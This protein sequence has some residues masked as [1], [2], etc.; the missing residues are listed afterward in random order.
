MQGELIDWVN[1]HPVDKI[2]RV[3]ALLMVRRKGLLHFSMNVPKFTPLWPYFVYWENKLTKTTTCSLQ[4]ILKHSGTSP[5]QYKSYSLG[6][7]Y[8][9]ILFSIIF[10]VMA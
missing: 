7:M 10:S 5:S 9:L 4:I 6:F 8:L 2:A 3:Y 1:C